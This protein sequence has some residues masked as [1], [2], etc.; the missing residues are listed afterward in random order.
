VLVDVKTIAVRLYDQ[1]EVV[2]AIVVTHEHSD[3]VR[4]RRQYRRKRDLPVTGFGSRATG[5][6]G[7]LLDQDTQHATL[8]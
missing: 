4:L 2:T 3:E 5:A 6:C 1:L 8:R 7:C